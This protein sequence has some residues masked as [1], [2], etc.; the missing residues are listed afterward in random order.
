[1]D[2]LKKARILIGREARTEHAL[3]GRTPRY[4][5]LCLI[6]GHLCELI[7]DNDIA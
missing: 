2:D 1:M 6:I 4:L 5:D 7:G 3:K